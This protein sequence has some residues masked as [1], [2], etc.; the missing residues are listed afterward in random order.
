MDG[1]AGEVY[2]ANLHEFEAPKLSRAEEAD[3]LNKV[4]DKLHL[5]L[6]KL[7]QVDEHRIFARQAR[8]KHSIEFLKN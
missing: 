5:F 1:I 7:P 8:L 4:L 3:Q 2:A 6:T